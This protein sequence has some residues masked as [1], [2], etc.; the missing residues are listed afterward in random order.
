VAFDLELRGCANY[1]TGASLPVMAFLLTASPHLTAVSQRQ[2]QGM[3]PRPQ[4]TIVSPRLEEI[5]GNVVIVE[6]RGQEDHTRGPVQTMRFGETLAL[7]PKFTASSKSL[8]V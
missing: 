2:R 1:C 3:S 5:V 6:A 4:P 8:N 7:R